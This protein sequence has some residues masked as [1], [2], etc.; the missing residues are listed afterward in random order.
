MSALATSPPRRRPSRAVAR[1]FSTYFDRGL[2]H[3]A[4]KVMPGAFL[5]TGDDI[6]LCT[7]LGSCVAAC[8]R[9]PLRRIGGMNHFLLP[10]D[11]AEARADDEDGAP[12]RYG[13]FAMEL[14]INALLKRGAR[15]ESLE[16]K[17]FGGGQ[18]MRSVSAVGVG[19]RNADFVASFLAAEGIPLLSS[20]LRG[21]YARRVVF[22]PVSGR[23]LCRP[24][25]RIESAALADEDRY[26]ATLSSR[27]P[28]GEIEL[29]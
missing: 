8:I 18:V 7:L 11:P 9:D 15:R 12:G 6:A 4:A 21:D 14:L 19:A 28:A 22:F 10:G 13:V 20:D 16:A 3:K 23:V 5:V 29:F 26:R 1:G 25:E 2:N 24:L 17:V 27:P